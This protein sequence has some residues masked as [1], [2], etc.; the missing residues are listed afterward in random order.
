MAL[1]NLFLAELYAQVQE[2]ELEDVVFVRVVEH[3]HPPSVRAAQK[4][5]NLPAGFLISEV[6]KL[7]ADYV[8]LL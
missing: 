4:A 1:L 5:L 8:P 3:G 7:V 2:Y 6:L